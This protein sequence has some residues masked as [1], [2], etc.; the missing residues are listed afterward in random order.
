MANEV[1]LGS[2]SS[3]AF[4][5]TES[6]SREAA[7]F[8]LAQQ[9]ED[10][11]KTRQQEVNEAVKKEVA[12][13]EET[14]SASFEEQVQELQSIVSMKGWYLNISKDNELGKT[15]VKLLDKDSGEVIRQIPSEELLSISKRFRELEQ[16]G[17][18]ERHIKGLLFD[19]SV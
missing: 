13:K 5:K 1:N 14:K 8:V 2:A 16:S 15:I 11:A 12:A 18:D 10:V 9:T 19:K 7:A 4:P 17:L 6:S 3:Y